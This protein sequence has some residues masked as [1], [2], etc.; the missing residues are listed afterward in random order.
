[1][2]MLIATATKAA[3][4][5]HRKRSCILFIAINYPIN[6]KSQEKKEKI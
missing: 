4:P 3:M 6:N 1:M 5:N 2:K